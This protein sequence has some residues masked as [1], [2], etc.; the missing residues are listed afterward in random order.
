MTSRGAQRHPGTRSLTPRSWGPDQ[1]PGPV[2]YD[3]NDAT[4]RSPDNRGSPSAHSA[5]GRSTKN[6]HFGH[7]PRRRRVLLLV[8]ACNGHP[9]GPLVLCAITARAR[10]LG[11]GGHTSA[12]EV[13]RAPG[14]PRKWACSKGTWQVPWQYVW[15]NSEKGPAGCC[16]AAGSTGRAS[17]GRGSLSR[18]GDHSEPAIHRGRPGARRRPSGVHGR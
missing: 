7:E 3:A 17:P 5:L 12:L 18:V 2:L 6:R 9:P 8:L 11:K 15:E 10:N 1:C 4:G 14:F 13:S 16:N